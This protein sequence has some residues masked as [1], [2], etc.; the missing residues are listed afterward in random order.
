MK[1]V[2]M[3][4]TVLVVGAAFLPAQEPIFT[5]DFESSTPS[6]DWGLYRE[7]EEAI[8]AVAMSSAPRPLTG[9]GEYVGKIQDA[10]A[11]YSGAAIILAGTTSDS[12]YTI[13]G[14]VYIYTFHPGGSAYT[15]LV[16][17][18]DSSAGTYYKLA[19]DFDANNRFRLYNNHLDYMT[20]VYT[21][22][23]EFDA[24]VVDTAE[25]WH[26]MMVKVETLEGGYPSFTC[27]YDGVMLGEGAYIDSSSD[28]LDSGQWGLYAFQM[29]SDG[30]AGYFDNIKVYH[31]GLLPADTP[32]TGIE[33]DPDY[34]VP[35]SFALAQNYPNPFNPSTTIDFQIHV[36]AQ[37]S[38]GIYDLSGRLVRTLLKGYLVPHR[39][40]VV[41]DGRDRSGLRVPSGVYIYSLTS[42]SR[43]EAKR[44][45]LL[46]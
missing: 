19:A 30:I 36:G 24:S 1:R 15:G 27:Y 33:P 32:T 29:D 18:A 44:M 28:R 3:V 10:D 13:E 14:D 7:G 17:Y 4:V 26:H 11:S 8:Q 22:Y 20:G 25:G 6:V 34:A 5:E 21:F 41:W 2:L 9:G 35:A 38:L 39:Y 37:T 42:G 43:S 12:N 31:G 16:V 23:Q 46:K 45:I 40:S